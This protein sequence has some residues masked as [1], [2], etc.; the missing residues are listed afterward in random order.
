MTEN[1]ELIAFR[2][3][4]EQKGKLQPDPNANAKKLVVSWCDGTDMRDNKVLEATAKLGQIET[5][6]PRDINCTCKLTHICNELIGYRDTK[7]PCGKTFNH[8]QVLYDHLR[9]DH[10]FAIVEYIQSL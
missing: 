9:T 1:T 10:N 8:W 4:K 2:I 7:C 6:D 5:E 3:T